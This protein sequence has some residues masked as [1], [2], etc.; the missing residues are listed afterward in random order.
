M[1]GR[2]RIVRGEDL[3]LLGPGSSMPSQKALSEIVFLGTGSSAGTP[4]VGCLMKG[5]EGCE[6]CRECVRNPYSKNVR[7]NPS[8]LI[9]YRKGGEEE[10][11][12]EE[13]SMAIEDLEATSTIVIDVGKTFKRSALSWFPKYKVSTLAERTFLE[14]TAQLLTEASEGPGQEGPRCL[15]H[16]RACRCRSGAG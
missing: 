16:A 7:N 10:S 12:A 13:E 3:I 6:I 11:T 2:G 8:L 14:Q 15:P 4:M 9:R 5:E 1:N